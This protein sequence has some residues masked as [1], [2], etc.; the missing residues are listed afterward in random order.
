[1]KILHYRDIWNAGLSWE[2]LVV[3]K[4]KEPLLNIGWLS[5]SGSLAKNWLSEPEK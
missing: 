2:K 5:D 4:R 1:M 3:Q